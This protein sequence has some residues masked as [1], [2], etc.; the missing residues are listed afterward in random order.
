MAYIMWVDFYFCYFFFFYLA[1][2]KHQ[3]P[4]KLALIIKGGTCFYSL[5]SFYF[6]LLQLEEVI[7]IHLVY[8][9]YTYI[10]IY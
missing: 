7:Y 3:G 10:C 8:T 4:R 6:A 2:S 5:L 1:I 9:L